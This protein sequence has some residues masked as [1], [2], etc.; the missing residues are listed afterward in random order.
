[1]DASIREIEHSRIAEDFEHAEREFRAVSAEDGVKI[2]WRA[3]EALRRW[4]SRM[5][6][7]L[8]IC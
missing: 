4:L 8:S 1:M 5:R 7:A 6:R 3:I 2:A